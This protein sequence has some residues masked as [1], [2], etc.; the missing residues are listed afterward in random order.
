MRTDRGKVLV[1]YDGSPKAQRALHEAAAFARGGGGIAVIHVIP[2]QS[3]GSRLVSLS[4]DQQA[5]QRRV[6][7]EAA[8]LL[9]KTGVE[10]EIVEAAGDP[11]T[12][13]LATSERL[14]VRLLA[15]GGHRHQF[16]HGIADRLVR[17]ALCDVLVVR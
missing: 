17:R 9:A 6:L 2:A 7:A 4:D 8:R 11:L 14:G 15:V 5:L 16:R 3:V 12:E 13:I 1:A 10:A